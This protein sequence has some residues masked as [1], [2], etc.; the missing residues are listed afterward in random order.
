MTVTRRQVTKGA[1]AAAAVAAMPRGAHA[2]LD[3]KS[4]ITVTV[5]GAT[6]RG[7]PRV[8]VEALNSIV[9]DS[10][11]G[12]SVTFKPSSPSGGLQ[13]LATGEAQI[14]VGASAPEIVYAFEGKAPYRTSLKG[15][16]AWVMLL[17]DQQ[18]LYSL[19]TKDWTQANGI[20]SYADIVAKKPKMRVALN[21]LGNLTVTV[22]GSDAIMEAYGFTANDIVK[23]GG[24]IVRGNS[25]IGK[26]A[27]QDAK[28]DV[29]LNMGPTSDAQLRD[30]AR[31]RELIWL[32]ADTAKLK[33]AADHWKNRVAVLK[34]GSYPFFDRDVQTIF[35]WYGMTAATGASEE[36]VYKYIKAVHENI[37]RVRKIHPILAGFS[38]QIM[39]QNPVGLPWHPGA[40]R[41]YREKGL[42]K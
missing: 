10:Y 32:D 3:D 38:D 21:E 4:P 8:I 37:E 30:I 2:A 19:A 35:G 20:K 7:Y 9:R 36:V 33:E 18:P 16:F 12:S 15:K 28:I 39:V 11:P 24:S 42:L 26:A 25:G 41:F 31:N 1:M 17:H 14:S 40:E 27:L 5:T 22:G 29:Y 34:K 6:V 23:W 13:Q